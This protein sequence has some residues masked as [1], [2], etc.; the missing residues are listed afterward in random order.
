MVNADG[1]HESP[2]LGGPNADNPAV[3]GRVKFFDDLTDTSSFE[4]G[5]TYLFGH[6]GDDPDFDANVFGLDLAYHWTDPDP[7]RFRSLLVQGELFWS[8]ND[9]DRG[10]FD[11]RR[12]DAFGAYAF[13][14]YQLDQNWYVGVRGDYTEYPNSE[15]RGPNDRDVALS[16]YATW[17]INE[18][19]RARLQYEHRWSNLDDGSGQEDAVFLQFTGVF[20]SHPP[21]PYWVRR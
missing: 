6:T 3:L 13:A 16:P 9:V 20:G 14:Q 8:H 2:I 11:S 1:G 10:P 7:S 15:T 17:Y 4:V 21:H 5:G 19:L 18:F 12:N